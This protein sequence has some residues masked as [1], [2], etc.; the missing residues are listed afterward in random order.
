[1]R[2]VLL[3][4]LIIAIAVSS[5]FALTVVPNPL[6]RNR[7]WFSIDGAAF[8]PQVCI[9]G[10]DTPCIV[11]LVTF[12]NPTHATYDLKITDATLRLVIPGLGSFTK[13]SLRSGIPKSLY[14]YT[15]HGCTPIWVPL[16][17]NYLEVLGL[18]WSGG[19]GSPIVKV[20][21]DVQVAIN[22]TPTAFVSEA[23]I[24]LTGYTGYHQTSPTTGV[25]AQPPNECLFP[26]V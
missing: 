10:I 3:A 6:V 25:P 15:L 7:P 18:N 21:L 8:Y 16:L 22:G 19:S 9:L 24:I 5:I 4:V 2:K 14:Y 12:H 23:D 13:N 11:I 1:M 17:F 20:E 26:W